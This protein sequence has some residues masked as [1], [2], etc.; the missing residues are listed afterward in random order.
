M[1][2]LWASPLSGLPP[3]SHFSL[4]SVQAEEVM[5]LHFYAALLQEQAYRA[6]SRLVAAAPEGGG[7]TPSPPPS[8]RKSRSAS[9][10]GSAAGDGIGPSLDFAAVAALYR[11]ASGVYRHIN[12]ELQPALPAE[13]LPADR[14]VE[15]YAGAA[16]ALAALSLAQAQ[17]VVAHRAEAGAKSAAVVASL[18]VGAAGVGVCSRRRATLGGI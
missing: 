8:A 2:F 13:G 11:R 7:G 5:A 10:D 15:L 9:P 3:T 17:G 1:G 18:H 14:P 6:A 4:G 16:A 12:A